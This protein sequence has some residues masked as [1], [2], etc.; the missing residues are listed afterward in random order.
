MQ[1]GPIIEYES[2]PQPPRPHTPAGGFWAIYIVAVIVGNSVIEPALARWMWG[3]PGD[4]SVGAIILTSIAVVSVLMVV[5]Y[6]AFLR[7]LSAGTG[8]AIAAVGG[9]L[10]FLPGY[11][12]LLFF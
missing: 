6:L 1:P 4:S 7:R 5:A 3:R 8:Y 9:V 2:P 12:F 10:S 11:G